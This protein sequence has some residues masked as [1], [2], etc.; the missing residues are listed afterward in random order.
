[1]GEEREFENKKVFFVCPPSIVQEEMVLLLIN[2][3]FEIYMLNDPD[4]VRRAMK[5]WPDSVFFFNIDEKMNKDQW[6]RFI[7]D[8]QGRFSDQ[9][10]LFGVLSYEK[11]PALVQHYLME[12]NL[13]CGFI[14]VNQNLKESTG[15]IA[16]T[17]EA[18]EVRGRRKFIR[19]IMRPNKFQKMNLSCNG[20]IVH[21]E[22]RDISAAAMVVSLD[23]QPCSKEKGAP[24]DDIQ[25]NLSGKRVKAS[26][27]LFGSR[28][29]PGQE[30]LYIISFNQKLGLKPISDIR[31]FIH[32]SL[33]KEME[34]QMGI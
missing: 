15:I 18:N 19:Y 28:Q 1:M 27:A 21:G 31:M 24:I 12:L 5:L 14:Q 7:L 30:S 6:E 9:R 29:Q 2:M 11:N 26:G 8:L 25:L 22:L 4:H 20:K 17:L 33:Q 23:D 13:P 16:K 3:E 10:C 32:K 34:E